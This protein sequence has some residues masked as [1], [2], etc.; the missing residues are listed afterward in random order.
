MAAV[1]ILSID[2]A[3]GS[4]GVPTQKEITVTFDQ[5]LD[6]NW[7][8][9]GNFFIEGSDREVRQGVFVPLRYSGTNPVGV[10][11]DPAYHGLL[12]DLG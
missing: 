2:P 10:I 8:R 4:I 9:D 3:N 7:V 12:G 6:P 5:P 11:S 1:T